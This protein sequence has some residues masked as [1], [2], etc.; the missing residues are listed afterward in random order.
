VTGGDPFNSAPAGAQ[1]VRLAAR[2]GNPAPIPAE[3]LGAWWRAA[4]AM[5]TA[6]AD[7]LRFQLLTGCRPGE[8][9]GI[10]VRDF[11]AKGERVT[12]RDTKNRSDHTLVLSKQ[13]AAIA[14]W[15]ADGAK[16]GDPLFGVADAGKSMAAINAT[17][18]VEG[19]T[20]H[21]LRHTFASV[22]A[23]LVPI[24]ALK[25]MLNHRGGSDVTAAHYVHVGEGQLRA[26]WQAV[27][28]YIEQAA[29]Q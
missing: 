25:A 8:V 16:P 10:K 17:A 1:R 15:H 28:D 4:C 2:K 14:Y 23:E 27:A 12:L 11:D 19:I 24:Y 3:R 29:A 20:A 26:A 9:A 13:A 7:Q 5:A 22:A 6:G 18:G 21:K